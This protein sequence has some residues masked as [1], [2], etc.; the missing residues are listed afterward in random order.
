MFYLRGKILAPPK[1]WFNH[2]LC[3]D[4]FPKTQHTHVLRISQKKISH[5][6]EPD[7]TTFK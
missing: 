4:G 1:I 7:T 2:R 3:S 6:I 5:S